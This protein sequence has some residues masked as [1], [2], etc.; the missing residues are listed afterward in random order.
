MKRVKYSRINLTFSLISVSFELPNFVMEL[1]A[2]L[3]EGEQGLVELSL[4]DLIVQ[5]DKSNVYETNI[6]V[7][8]KNRKLSFF[9]SKLYGSSLRTQVLNQ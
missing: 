5:Y 4:G 6:Q 1:K 7:R 8:R 3:G 9:F 2:D